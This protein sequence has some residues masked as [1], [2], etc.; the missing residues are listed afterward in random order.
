MLRHSVGTFCE[1]DDLR[2]V[3][4][5]RDAIATVIAAGAI[6]TPAPPDRLLGMI[7]GTA[8]QAI[9]SAAGALLL[10]DRDRGVL[11]TE[12]AIGATAR[13]DTCPLGYGVAG[14]VVASGQPL[15]VVDARAEGLSSDGRPGTALAAPVLAPD[16]TV[17]GV[18]ELRGRQ[19]QP[20]FDQ[21]DSEL[22]VAFAAQLASVLDLRRAHHRLGARVGEAIAALGN[23]PPDV[24]RVL[25][26][27]AEEF[28]ARVEAAATSR[29]TGELAELVA[30]I[31]CRGE[32][33]VEA[34]GRV[35]WT[36]V[37]YLDARH[38]LGHLSAD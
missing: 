23:L 33:E 10:A 19:R 20:A 7:V 6:D 5:L 34:C 1:Q 36:F 15:T 35:L 22:A 8:V 18:L 11:I 2:F 28:V 4:E 29:R 32:D 14:R 38:A 37:E 30:A 13:G 31:A 9:P 27:R 17:A 16:G 3:A 25:G 21:H 24:A 26:K 12:V